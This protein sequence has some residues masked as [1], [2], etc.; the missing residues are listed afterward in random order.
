M[1]G[2]YANFCLLLL[3]HETSLSSSLVEWARSLVQPAHSSKDALL[4]MIDGGYQSLCNILQ[5]SLL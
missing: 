1:A 3:G 4:M 2:P 5:I